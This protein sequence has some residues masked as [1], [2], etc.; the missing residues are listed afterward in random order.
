MF[1]LIVKMGWKLAN[2]R[3]F[4]VR[5]FA[6]YADK[7]MGGF[8]RRFFAVVIA[9]AVFLVSATCTSAGCLL[10]LPGT[11]TASHASCCADLSRSADGQ[12]HHS[13]KPTKKSCPICGQPLFPASTVSNGTAQVSLF[14]IASPMV[15][16]NTALAVIAPQ[17]QAFHSY[18]SG[19]PPPT[20]PPTLIALHCSLLI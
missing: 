9:L 20:D 8:V 11:K 18:A 17:T 19:L 10:Q 7:D 5:R 13:D 4:D 16:M 14:I 12:G 6:A 1:S 15:A 3:D 2:S